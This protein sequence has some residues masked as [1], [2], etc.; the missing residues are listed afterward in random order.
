MTF[1]NPNLVLEAALRNDKRLGRE[2]RYAT[3]TIVPL[4]GQRPTIQG[5][6]EILIFQQAEARTAYFRALADRDDLIVRMSRRN[7]RDVDTAAIDCAQILVAHT[8]K[9]WATVNEQLLDAHDTLDGT[10]FED[11]GSAMH[12]ML[13]VLT[14]PTGG[15]DDTAQR[16][17]AADYGVGRC[18]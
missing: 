13:G 15:G 12:D 9:Q 5:K 11:V 18:A 4:S 16:L 7:L 8:E 1:S 10:L 6:I 2:P 14:A 17:G 3:A